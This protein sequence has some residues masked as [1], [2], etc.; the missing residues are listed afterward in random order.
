MTKRSTHSLS[1]VKHAAAVCQT[2]VSDFLCVNGL[3][4]PICLGDNPSLLIRYVLLGV[5]KYRC[6]AAHV[7]NPAAGTVQQG[8]A[9]RRHRPC[10][11]LL[12][13][14][15]SA[16]STCFNVGWLSSA[17]S[18]KTYRGWQELGAGWGVQNQCDLVE[19]VLVWGWG[20]SSSVCGCVAGQQGQ[21]DKTFCV[22]G[23]SV[24]FV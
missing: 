4:S 9:G 21:V 10:L 13:P 15:L 20:S 24:L 5:R 1:F 2:V 17:S 12:P 18:G 22:S 6:A 23:T 7:L 16:A 11:W 3:C 8:A 14:V 19:S